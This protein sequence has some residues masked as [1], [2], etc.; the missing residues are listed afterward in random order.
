MHSHTHIYPFCRLS[1]YR[2]AQFNEDLM[3]ANEY[4][5]FNTVDEI[6]LPV[7]ISALPIVHISPSPFQ[8]WWHSRPLELTDLGPKQGLFVTKHALSCS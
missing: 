4:V 1:L 7:R 2:V 5:M 3:A 6:P 8:I